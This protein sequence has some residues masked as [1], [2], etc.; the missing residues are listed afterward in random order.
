MKNNVP[1]I[2]ATLIR[3]WPMLES[4]GGKVF[5]LDYLKLSC[6][7]SSPELAHGELLG[8]LAFR[9]PSSVVRPQ[10]FVNTLVDTV[11]GLS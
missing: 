5:K 11:L 8:S 4:F 9:R 1:E 2:T 7:F 6:F 10:L 3:Y